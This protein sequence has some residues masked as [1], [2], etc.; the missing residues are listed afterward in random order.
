MRDVAVEQACIVCQRLTDRLAATPIDTDFGLVQVTISTGIATIAGD[1]EAAMMAAD[2][3][4]YGAKR[5]GRSRL[6][7]VA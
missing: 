2:S 7:S 6:S 5:A 3:A 1:G 4:L